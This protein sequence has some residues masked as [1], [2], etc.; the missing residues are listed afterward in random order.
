[1][2]HTAIHVAAACGGQCALHHVV[3]TAQQLVLFT[4]AAC[5]DVGITPANAR[6]AAIA[7]C[8]L[9]SHGHS[10]IHVYAS[11]NFSN[12]WGAGKS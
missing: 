5:H 2:W 4:F 9:D 11:V 6:S 10:Q 7:V 12:L 3:A 8:V 1:M